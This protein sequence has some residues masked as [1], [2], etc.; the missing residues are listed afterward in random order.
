MHKIIKIIFFSLIATVNL[1]AQNG[2]VYLLFNNYSTPE[3]L[4]SYYSKKIA[5][6]KLGFIWI[7]TQD[8]LNRFDGKQFIQ[9]NKNT[10]QKIAGND[11]T[12][13]VMD[14]AH[15]LVWVST[16]LGGI[17]AIDIQTLKVKTE[18]LVNSPSLNMN[19]WIV[20]MVLVN[21]KLWIGTNNG[22]FIYDI[23]QNKITSRPE[24]PPATNDNKVS[25]INKLV[26]L[27][28]N[29]VI[30]LINKTTLAAYNT[31]DK[32][33]LSLYSAVDQNQSVNDM[34][35]SGHDT[36]L[37]ATNSGILTMSLNFTG[38]A[39]KLVIEKN[40][41][42]DFIPSGEIRCIEAP[43][44]NTLLAATPEGL[45]KADANS[46]SVYSIKRSS[47]PGGSSFSWEGFINQL[48][49][50]SNHNLWLSTAHGI[51]VSNSVSSPFTAYSS[52]NNKTLNISHPFS[53][54]EWSPDQYL[55]N[56]DNGLII[57]DKS[58]NKGEKLYPGIS[59]YSGVTVNGAQLLT[60]STGIRLFRNRTLLSPSTLFPELGSIESEKMGPWIQ[61]G[62]SI[63]LWAGYS[64]QG[65]WKWNFRRKNVSLVSTGN[66]LSRQTQ[67]VNSF[68][69]DSPTTILIVCLS[70]LYQY[71]LVNGSLTEIPIKDAPKDA[72]FYDI[73]HQGNNYLIGTYGDGILVY[74]SQFRLV[75]KIGKKDGLPNENIYNF[76][77][78]GENKLLATTNFG[79]AVINTGNYSLRSYFENDGLASNSFEYNFHI[80]YSGHATFLPSING[81]TMVTP[82]HFIT[83]TA[84][85]KIYF[86]KV[87]IK[88]T[89]ANTETF[90]AAVKEILIP[91]NFLQTTI[92]FSGLDFSNPGRLRYFYRI[93]KLSNEWINNEDKNFIP[94]I[95]MSPGK[96]TLQV[97]AV[98]EEGTESD[99]KELV[100]NFLP[101][102]YQTWWFK[103]LLALTI[104]A[105]GYSLYRL[106][107]NQ[108]KKEQRIRT[109]IASDLHDDLGSTMNSVKVYAN[110]ALMEKQADKYLPLIKDGTQNAIN[111]IRDIIWVLDDT[112]DS[113]EQLL[114]RIS[115]FAVP[116]CE[117]NH[118][119]YKQ[120]LSD[121]ARDHKLGQEERRNLYMIM[122]E[123]VNNTI[124]YSGATNLDITVSLKKG[125]PTI[126][127]R[128]NGKGF[129]TSL[130]SDGNG[131]KNMNCRAREIKYDCQIDS[132]P[133]K[134]TTLFFGKL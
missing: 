6:D 12:D 46:R 126:Q 90:D 115:N 14:D 11:V 70:N 31:G 91:D 32:E 23:K 69:Q 55:V 77:S 22:I 72:I 26:A 40:K 83:S 54:S 114:A 121:N 60:T 5:E 47:E 108:L 28:D 107:I 92:Y 105:I 37:L 134:G 58:F 17:N 117:A 98:T 27:D 57:C 29:R 85:P 122:K 86:E 95:S 15:G 10:D 106:R 111:G 67:Q 42:F 81:L 43:A 96:Y 75:K 16:A 30:A 34:C 18:F 45:L 101:K 116:L 89:T 133:G 97:K 118:I 44:N 7:A 48:Y 25:R 20:S 41:Q 59:F 78:L 131:L 53:V 21:N 128:D 94:L 13:I 2:N 52:L 68:Y 99:I 33:V 3:G 88:T 50:D 76:Y 113:I 71:S 87:S 35:L 129:D 61:V 65:I 110:L 130:N 103:T 127:I 104:I 56:T 39:K 125:K 132:A 62:D 73:S 82:G 38:T 100:L 119:K 120:E 24:L 112:K 80:S 66:E 123:A 93:A 51:M 124:K 19:D 102:W 84:R 9:F 4:S 1:K 36:L 63:I 49:Y 8:G 74:D 79:A 109:K 64:G